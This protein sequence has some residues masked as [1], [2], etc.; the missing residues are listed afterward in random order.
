MFPEFGTWYFFFNV[1]EEKNSV[2]SFLLVGWCTMQF[3]AK[4]CLSILKIVDCTF[5]QLGIE[6]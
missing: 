4:V 2:V 5:M 3:S 6:E 1:E